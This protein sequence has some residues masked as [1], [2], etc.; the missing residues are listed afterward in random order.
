MRGSPNFARAC[1]P[2]KIG[3]PAPRCCGVNRGPAQVVASLM[4]KTGPH[5]L[6]R[7]STAASFPVNVPDML[8]A[9]CRVT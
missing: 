1:G 3:S 4:P 6:A 5:F 9:A 7:C 8:D 2:H